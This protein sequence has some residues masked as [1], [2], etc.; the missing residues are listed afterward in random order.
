MIVAMDG[1]AG[2]GKSTVARLL[3]E[4]LGFRLIDTG[5][6]YRCV[7]LEGQRRG[8]DTFAAGAHEQLG[9]IARTLPIDF[10]FFDGLNRI[11]LAGEDVTEAIRATQ[12]SKAASEVSAVPAVRTALVDRQRILGAANDCVMEGRDIGT[13]V[14]P[15][16]DIKLFLTASLD[17]RSR[18]RVVQ[19]G[20]HASAS[21][22]VTREIAD[23]DARDMGRAV[24]PLR[25]ADDAIEV[26]TTNL[27]LDQVID[28]VLGL[29][30]ARRS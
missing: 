7:A 29:V 13:V 14:F 4:R 17:A 3:A 25:K 20:V 30:T 18:R 5:A 27:E 24:A 19:S 9:E 15:D 11:L 16:A 8:I 6:M 10:R 22:E 12:V 23:R 1:P 26:D 21:A 2:A 28:L